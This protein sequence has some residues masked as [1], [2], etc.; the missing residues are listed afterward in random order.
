MLTGRINALYLGDNRTFYW[1]WS[2]ADLTLQ[3]YDVATDKLVWERHYRERQQFATQE[4]VLAAIMDRA[5][6]DMK[7]E[8]FLPLTR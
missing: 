3:A 5:I 7:R 6:A 8:V 1:W 4:D 2:V